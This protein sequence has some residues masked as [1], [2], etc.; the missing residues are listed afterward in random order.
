MTDVIRLR[1]L[2]ILSSLRNY[3]VQELSP[4]LDTWMKIIIQI[5]QIECSIVK[6]TDILRTRFND[7]IRPI[8]SLGSK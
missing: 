4:H 1:G 3:D 6:M 8:Y 2:F 5:L 7:R